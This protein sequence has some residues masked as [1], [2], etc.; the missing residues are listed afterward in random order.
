MFVAYAR[1]TPYMQAFIKERHPSIPADQREML[2][3]SMDMGIVSQEVWIALD[4]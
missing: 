2:A 1:P 4:E 3:K